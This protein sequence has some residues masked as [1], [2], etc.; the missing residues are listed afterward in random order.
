MEFHYF[1]DQSSC[2]QAWGDFSILHH[3][4]EWRGFGRCLISSLLMIEQY[5][6]KQLL[7]SDQVIE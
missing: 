7:V 3:M 4:K 2:S 6:Y 5:L 1:V